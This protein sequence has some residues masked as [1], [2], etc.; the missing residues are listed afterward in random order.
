METAGGPATVTTGATDLQAL[1]EKLD[2]VKREVDGLQI[3]VMQESKPWWQQIPVIVSVAASLFS[4][5]TWWDSTRRTSLDQRHQAHVELRQIIQRLAIIQREATE[6]EE[7]YKSYPAT[8][9]NNL[10]GQLNGEN[11]I[12]AG[13]ARTIIDELEM[14][15]EQVSATEKLAVAN[16]FFTAGEPGVAEILTTAA[17]KNPEGA[18]M[19]ERVSAARSMAFF[20]FRSGRIEDGRKFYEQASEATINA[21]VD[22]QVAIFTQFLT[23]LFWAE[24]ELATGHCQEATAKLTTAKTKLDTFPAFFSPLNRAQLNEAEGRLRDCRS[25]VSVPTAT[26]GATESTLRH[27]Q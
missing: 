21:G 9:R 5:F 16:A 19:I 25:G 20:A 6:L 11:L 26:R 23:D 24:A 1:R 13:V 7:K 10:S 12:L 18:G 4:M 2:D 3:H 14:S 15:G 22:Q 8:V 27:A 17:L